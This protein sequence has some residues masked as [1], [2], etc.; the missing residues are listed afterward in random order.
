MMD[1]KEIE[2]KVKEILS[3]KLDIDINK[4]TLESH[5]V[6]DLG[7]DSFGAIE[8]MYAIEEIFKLEFSEDDL[9]E[10][11]CVKDISNMVEERLNVS[12]N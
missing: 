4:I 2:Q 6:D 5:L 7:M 3:E 11:K 9:T 8:I 12:N 10:V 1:K